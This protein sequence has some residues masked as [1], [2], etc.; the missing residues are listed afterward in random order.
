MSIKH[1]KDF[2]TEAIRNHFAWGNIHALNV[3]PSRNDDEGAH[4]R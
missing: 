4:N 1:A 2:V 3:I